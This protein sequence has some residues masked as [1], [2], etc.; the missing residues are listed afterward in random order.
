MWDIIKLHQDSEAVTSPPPLQLAFP[1]PQAFP[2]SPSLFPLES[3]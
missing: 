2:V 3:L 1:L